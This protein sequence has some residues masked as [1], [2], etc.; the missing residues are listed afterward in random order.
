MRLLEEVV[1]RLMPRVSLKVASSQ[2]QMSRDQAGRPIPMPRPSPASR[3]STIA[4]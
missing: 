1:W 3:A 2:G 4:S